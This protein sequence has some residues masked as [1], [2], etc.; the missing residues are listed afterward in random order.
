MTYLIQSS[1]NG[2]DSEVGSNSRGDHIKK[3]GLKE[4]GMRRQNGG[5]NWSFEL[6]QVDEAESR[7][8]LLGIT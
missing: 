8:S 7:R 3:L 5:R 2:K 4:I 1:V 6:L